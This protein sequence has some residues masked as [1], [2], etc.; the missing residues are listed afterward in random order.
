MPKNLPLFITFSNSSMPQ[1]RSTMQIQSTGINLDVFLKIMAMW[2]VCL[3]VMN[4]CLLQEL[5]LNS[6]RHSC[7]VLATIFCVNGLFPLFL[8][9]KFHHW[10]ESISFQCRTFKEGFRRYWK[11]IAINGNKRSFWQKRQ[12]EYIFKTNC[13]NIT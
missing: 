10:Y 2:I 5:T 7:D 8:S 4:V 9:K 12:Q 11:Q 1:S 3:F 13:T 6:I